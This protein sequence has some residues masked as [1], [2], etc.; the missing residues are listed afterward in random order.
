MARPD[1]RRA[2]R[3][4]HRLRLIHA[5]LRQWS[6]VADEGPWYAAAGSPATRGKLGWAPVASWCSCPLCAGG[7]RRRR[8]LPA[9][10]WEDG[11]EETLARLGAGARANLLEE[12]CSPSRLRE[13]P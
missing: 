3:R 5:R 13:R 1:S 8:H 2:L 9:Q 6:Y 7:K 4:H 10:W 12:G 11:R